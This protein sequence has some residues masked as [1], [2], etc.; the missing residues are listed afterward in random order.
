MHCA[1]PGCDCNHDPD[2][3]IE[4]GDAHYCNE[5]CAAQDPGNDGCECGHPDCS[6]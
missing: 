6:G 4:E 1:H 2:E 5:A 3:M